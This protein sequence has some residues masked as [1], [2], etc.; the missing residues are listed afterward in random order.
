[1]KRH[2]DGRFRGNRAPMQLS[3]RKS[4]SE[5]VKSQTVRLKRMGVGS[6]DTIAELLT[7]AGRGDHVPTVVLPENVTFPPNYRISK[8]ACCK[9][10]RSRM[11][12]EPNLEAE[13]HRRLDTERCEE[14]F[15]A[16]QANVRKGDTK[17]VEAAV[18]VLGHKA[19][20]LGLK[21]P[22]RVEMTGKDEGPMSVAMFRQLCEEAEN[23]DGSDKK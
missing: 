22:T 15:F 8:M 2:P 19:E 21:R 5:W 7:K 11:E 13:E 1:M 18:R 9:A 17:S 6:F 4:I 3:N 14:M 20:L 10:Y 16:M 23:E 12:H